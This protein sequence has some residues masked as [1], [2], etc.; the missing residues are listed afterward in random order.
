MIK[1]VQINIQQP[2]I[3]RIHHVPVL[4]IQHEQVASMKELQNQ[5]AVQLVNMLQHNQIYYLMYLKTKEKCG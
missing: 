5:E 4:I 2:L 1:N 3:K